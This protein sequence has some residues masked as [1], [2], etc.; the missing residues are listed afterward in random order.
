MACILA[1]NKVD[2]LPGVSRC[3]M[4]FFPVVVVGGRSKRRGTLHGSHPR[5]PP[6]FDHEILP[7]HR[8][9]VRL[10]DI[11]AGN[12]SGGGR[13]VAG[14]RVACLN[15]HVVAAHAHL[16]GVEP[17][18]SRAH[19]ELPPV[20]RAT[21]NFSLAVVRIV[22]RRWRR[23]ETDQATRAECRPLMRATVAQCEER[24]TN[25]EHAHATPRNFDDLPLTGRNLAHAGDD[26]L[27]GKILLRCAVA[28]NRV[29]PAGTAAWRS[30]S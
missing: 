6:N 15:G 7:F 13:L 24:A 23:D 29:T 21:E 22:P 8:Y 9:G 17:R 10:G 28:S 11:R 26:M 3:C 2:A 14:S 12:E 19:V 16:R 25:V 4:L 1:E 5:S 20:P 18:P 30:P 27:D